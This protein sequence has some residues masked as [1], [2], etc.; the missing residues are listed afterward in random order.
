MPIDSDQSWRRYGEGFQPVDVSVDNMAHIPYT[1]GTTGDPKG[2]VLTLNNLITSYFARYTFSSYDVGD[3]VGCNIFYAWEFLRP[4]LKG[5]TVYPIP[6]EVMYVPRSLAR[7]IAEH[8]LTE[9]LFTSSLFQSLLNS[10]SG[11]VLR[12][13]L[14]SLRVIWQAGEVLPVSLLKQAQE[15]IPSAR[16]LNSYS[17]SET[18]D[19]CTIDL[20]DYPTDGMTICP[21][22]YVMDGVTI[23]VR[24]EDEEST[25]LESGTG[26]LLIGGVGL[27]RE[28][29]KKPELTADRFIVI[30][31]ERYYTTGDLAEVTPDGLVTIVGRTDSMVKVRGYTVYL[32]AIEEMLR[33][34]CGV[35]E[36]A[37]LVEELDETNKRL[38]AYVVRGENATW[39]VDAASGASKDLRNILERHLPLYSVPFHY[40]ELEALP[41]NQR[42]G[43]L[44]RKALP[45]FGTRS[46]LIRERT[47]LPD[48]ATS[49]QKRA[50]MRE[51]WA[52]TLNIDID[53]LS[54]DWNF[55]DIGGHSLAGVVLTLGIE[56][57]FGMEL[58]GME[59]YE[60]QTIES[61]MA[62]LERREAW[63]GIRLNPR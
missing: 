2:V 25:I 43:K 21:V 17:I 59:V 12:D 54:D 16:I 40:V 47:R 32:G 30:D 62:F 50:A 22:G 1:S 20:T 27:A 28:Y 46:S 57:T 3:R 26:E 58:S 31:G 9:T 33:R 29:L 39:K 52:E 7:F 42:I 56:E 61:L 41:I 13:Q 53:T 14:S 19:V 48:D 10:A 38:V 4:L 35:S 55:F 18:H 36:A 6:D 63:R 49:E 24:P 45:S 5:G 11:D 51:I 23:R 15:I 34:H 37:V 8:R 44:D 60:H